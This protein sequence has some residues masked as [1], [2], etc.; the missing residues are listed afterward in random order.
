MNPQTETERGYEAVEQIK[1]LA[2][3]LGD[4]YDPAGVLIL[5]AA[6]NRIIGRA[7]AAAINDRD[8]RELRLLVRFY[9]GVADGN[10]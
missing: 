5:I 10:F 7:P 4:I 9:E 6:P 3:A 2:K 8:I 1:R